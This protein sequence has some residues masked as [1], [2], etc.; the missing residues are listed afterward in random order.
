MFMAILIVHGVKLLTEG[1]L[2]RRGW[3]IVEREEQR[4]GVGN[5]KEKARQQ[6]V[7]SN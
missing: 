2:G 7:N 5:R 1:D 6:Y 3:S 4:A